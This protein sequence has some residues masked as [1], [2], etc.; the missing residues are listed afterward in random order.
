MNKFK[1]FD[2][3]NFPIFGLLTPFVGEVPDE[4]RVGGD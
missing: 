3:I 4:F 1:V 2:V